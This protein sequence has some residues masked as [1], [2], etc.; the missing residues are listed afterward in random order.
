MSAVLEPIKIEKTEVP[1][2]FEEDK[3]LPII[4]MQ[5]IFKNSGS[6]TDTKDGL[7][8]LTAKLLNEG[9]KKDG[10]VGFATKLESRAISLSTHSGA[11]TFVIELGSLKSEFAHGIRLM[12]ELIKDPNYSKETLEKI[13]TQTIGILKR[14]ESDFDYI[15][16]LAMK[17]MVFPNTPLAKAS[18]G[19]V[20]SVESIGLDDIKNHIAEHLGLEN[21]I[22]VMGGDINQTEASKIV[23]AVLSEFSSIKSVDIKAMTPIGKQQVKETKVKSEQAYIYFGA[24]FSVAYDSKE[25]HLSQVAS[26]VLGSGGFGSRIME[27]IRVKKGL[28]YSAYT[29]FIINKSHSYFFGYLQTKIESGD[30][31]IKSV[32][33]VVQLFLDRGVTKEELESAK[34]FILGSEPLR[35]ETLSQRLGRAFQEYYTDRPL[36]STVEELKLIEDMKLDDLNEFIKR[37]KE[38]AEISFSVVTG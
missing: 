38:I 16:T 8:K 34:Q 25:R 22:V 23:K 4:S 24:P 6:L 33:E 12:K 1:F 36:G 35:N 17:S 31:A 15:S 37:H 7:V 30:E 11:E 10:S 3:N 5:L 28:A 14:K 21:A 19:T 32:K 27:E 9:T 18:L 26:F 20:K 29:R 13:K 2:I